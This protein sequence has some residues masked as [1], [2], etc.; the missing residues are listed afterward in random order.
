MEKTKKVIAYSLYKAP[1]KW[2]NAMETNFKKYTLGL[3]RNLDLIS[4]FYP[5]WYVYLYHNEELDLNLIE[6]FQGYK[7]LE[8]K[9]ITNK[10]VNAMQWRF[11]PHDDSDVERFI[12][13]DLDSRI[14]EREV[15]SVM[16]WIESDKVI[17]IM[18]DHPH[19]SYLILG[20]MWGM[21]SQD[22]LNMEESCI[23]YNQ[24]KNYNFNTGWYDK[25]WDMKFLD[26]IIYPKY[27]EN[28]YINSELVNRENH[29]KDFTIKRVDRHFVGEIFDENDQRAY[30]YTLL[31]D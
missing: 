16:E 20:G 10:Q 6:P 9:C 19:H 21:K 17:H 13:R 28:S 2:E 1:E 31:R 12:S 4:K 22:D 3:E 26:D 25:W 30:H 14:T 11:L 27:K 7:N 5:N 8:L 18:R 29:A 24:S 23:S 15:V